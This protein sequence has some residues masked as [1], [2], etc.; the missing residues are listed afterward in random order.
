MLL[1]DL[2]FEL[3][4]DNWKF[5]D[6]VSHKYMHRNNWVCLQTSGSGKLWQSCNNTDISQGKSACHN[7][8]YDRVM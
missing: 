7:D 4:T 5:Y 8:P 2:A 3:K 6:K 1:K